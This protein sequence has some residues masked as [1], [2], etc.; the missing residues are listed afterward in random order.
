MNIMD[1]IGGVWLMGVV[2]LVMNEFFDW[3]SKHGA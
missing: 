3:R 1:A 2:Y